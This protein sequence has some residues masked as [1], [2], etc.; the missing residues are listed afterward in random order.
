MSFLTWFSYFIGV[1]ASV[2]LADTTLRT[3]PFTRQRYHEITARLGI[4]IDILQAR[5]FTQRFNRLFQ[6]LCRFDTLPWTA[7]FTCGVLFSVVC[8]SFS[9]YLFT[10]LVYNTLMQKPIKGGTLTPVMPGVNLPISHLGFYMLTLLLCAFLHEAGHALAALRERVRLHGFGLFLF[11]FYPG[12]FVDLNT[13]DLQSLTPF[14]QLRVYCAG[15]WHNAVIAVLSIAVFYSMPVLL[16]PGYHT[17]N[18]VGVTFLRENSVVT[19]HRGLSMGDTITRINSCPVA[20]QSDWFHCLEMAHTRPSGYCVSGLYLNTMDPGANDIKSS[21]TAGRNLAAYVSKFEGNGS[22]I[23]GEEPGPNVK[24]PLAMDCC[25]H[26]PASTH[27]C[28]TYLAPSKHG[29]KSPRYACLPARPVTERA[30][31]HSASDCGPPS[32]VRASVNSGGSSAALSDSAGMHVAPSSRSVL[33]VVPSPPDNQ[34]RLV[35]L[36]HNRK[37]APAILFLGPLEDLIASVGVSDYVS[38]WPSLLSP[39]FPALLSLFCSYLFSISGALALLNVIPCYALDGQWILGALID[40]CLSGCLPCRRK[41]QCLFRLILFGGT[42]LLCTNLIFACWYF[43]LDFST[44]DVIHA[45]SVSTIGSA[46]VLG[47]T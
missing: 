41:R 27:L 12:A 17:G 14:S 45:S 33:C 43:F 38:R 4:S 7:W 11:G 2:Y 46:G 29:Y 37:E 5:F 21:Q 42:V 9:V 34:T 39:K 15:V 40:L 31:C 32:L 44:V 18:G 47:V 20:N 8:M 35:R 28:F 26:Q 30:T 25:A 19:G 3:L 36:V 13:A 23:A 6:F 10:L 16:S 22:V 1:W 24:I